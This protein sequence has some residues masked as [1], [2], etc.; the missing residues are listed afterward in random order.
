[1]SVSEGSAELGSR[2]PTHRLRDWMAEVLATCGVAMDSARVVADVLLTAELKGVPSHGLARL[3]IYVKRL[4]LGLIRANPH[5]GILCDSSTVLLIDADN[6]LG[7]PAADWGVRRIVSKA[8]EAGIAICGVA[9]SSHF[10]M[11]GYYAEVAARQGVICLVTTN[12]ASRVAPWG[13][14]DRLFGTNP[15]AIAVPGPEEEPIVLDMATSVAAIGKIM[16]AAKQNSPIPV[17]WAIDAEGKPTTDPQAALEGSLL[18]IGDAKGAGLAFMLDV[19][20]GV[21]TGSAFGRSVGSQNDLS[22]PEHCGHTLIAIDV[23]AF[24]PLPDFKER[25]F[26]YLQ[27]FKQ[28]RPRPG[29]SSVSLP[30]ENQRDHE[31]RSREQGIALSALALSECRQLAENLGI[32]DVLTFAQG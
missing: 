20:S 24:L 9:N 25:L 28:C 23:A 29:V 2:I 18:P 4:E 22:R 11:A 27:E 7:H 21:L 3:P 6:G 15:I 14:I 30:G 19:L 12:A 13:A 26:K 17:G 16:L 8:K 32:V 5:R 31:Y 10:G 1:V